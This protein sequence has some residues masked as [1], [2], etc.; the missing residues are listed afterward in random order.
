MPGA[1]PVYG[2]RYP[3]ATDVISDQHF[4][5]FADD[6]SAILAETDAQLLRAIR[7]QYVNV[8]ASVGGTSY[9]TG[10][11][12][13]PVFGFVTANPDGLYSA[14]SPT[15]ILTATRNGVFLVQ[16]T[17]ATGNGPGSETSW[18]LSLWKNGSAINNRE[19][20]GAANMTNPSFTGLVAL[21]PV[22]VGDF[23]QASLIWTGTAGPQTSYSVQ[24][25]ATMICEG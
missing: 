10:V 25:S 2:I 17:N 7:R 18:T 3:V 4:E 9:A 21:V 5:D 14:G 23:I 12:F 8:A 24:A 15:R 13:N 1:T 11:E 6:V 22:L 16:L 20:R 19:R